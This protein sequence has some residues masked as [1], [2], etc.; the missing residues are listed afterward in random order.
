MADSKLKVSTKDSAQVLLMM[1]HNKNEL[2]SFLESGGD[3]SRAILI[4][5]E[6][7]CIRPD[8]YKSEV[9]DK[10]GL[11]LTF[12]N[13]HKNYLQ[14]LWPY[15]INSDPCNPA[16]SI[17]PK[18]LILGDKEFE[19]KED[20]W[21]K[22]MKFLVLIA[23]NKVSPVRDNNY[24]LR[25]KLAR[26]ASRS[27]LELY[28][29][30]WNYNIPERAKHRLAVF[31]NSLKRGVAPSVREIWGGM[32]TYY[33]SNCGKIIDKHQTLQSFKFSLVV[34]NSDEVLTEKL[35]DS[36]MNG[37]IPIYWGPKTLSKKLETCVIRTETLDVKEL[38]SY[39][40]QLDSDFVREKFIAMTQFLNSSEFSEWSATSVYGCLFM[41]CETYLAKLKD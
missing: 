32:L 39:L 5:T 33:P 2:S 10:Y 17:L 6:P 41:E 29:S 20:Q 14:L 18:Q 8:Q 25:R 26:S 4:R 23:A 13:V 38:C 35:F 31:V 37:T 30:M 15:E 16:E 27:H 7:R 40:E 12:G 11:V 28:G 34:E 1:D 21:A 3:K 22:R 36:I 19:L 9:T 24:R